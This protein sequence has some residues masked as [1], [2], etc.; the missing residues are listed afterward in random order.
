MHKSRIVILLLSVISFTSLRGQSVITELTLPGDNIESIQSFTSRENIYLFLN[1]ADSVN[2]AYQIKPDGTHKQLTFDRIENTLLVGVKDYSDSSLFY[3]LLGK[4]QDIKLIAMTYNYTTGKSRWLEEEIKID[5]QVVGVSNDE[6]FSIIYYQRNPNQFKVIQLKGLEIENEKSFDLPMS[7]S[8]DYKYITYIRDYTLP[9]IADGSAKYKLYKKDQQLIFSIDY[10]LVESTSVDPQTTV[11]TFDLQNGEQTLKSYPAKTN[12]FFRSF[13]RHNSLYRSAM[14]KNKFELEILKIS[15]GEILQ[16]KELQRD[17]ALK[18]TYVYLKDGKSQR[19]NKHETLY[20]MMKNSVSAEPS[21]IALPTNDT[22]RT[23]IVWS[24]Y[25][26]NENIINITAPTNINQD[27]GILRM[28][29]TVKHGPKKPTSLR[30]YFYLSAN[31]HHEFE[32]EGNVKSKRETIDEYEIAQD[33]K[34][35]FYTDRACFN[36]Q[37]N[38]IALYFSE[39]QSKITLVKF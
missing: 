20:D 12:D 27:I 5:G 23:T 22:C 8:I 7:L 24:T 19:I 15:N 37:N 28:A 9:T 10:T 25:Y 31:C 26:A 34:K 32:T 38:I 17:T 6:M 29:G 14:S 18:R 16:K 36:F 33:K 35:I 2:K 21:V 39:K 30:R 11:I 4:K 1:E 13:V 3:Y